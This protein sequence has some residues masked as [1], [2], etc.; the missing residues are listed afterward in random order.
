M[1]RWIHAVRILVVV[2]LLG[3]GHTLAQG[4]VEAVWGIEQGFVTLDPADRGSAPDAHFEELIFDRLI[5]RPDHFNL[6]GTVPEWRPG[7]ATSW[8]ANADGTVWTFNLRQG[9]EFHKGYGPFTGDDVKFSFDRMADP[10]NNFPRQGE[11]NMVREI[12]IVDDYTVEMRLVEPFAPFLLYIAI[13]EG[14]KIVSRRAV[15]EMGNAQFAQNPIGTGPY[16][17]ESAVPGG[18]IVVV[19]NEAYWGGRPEV[20]VAR[21]VVIPDQSVQ[22]LA[23]LRGEVDWIRIRDSTIYRQLLGQPGIQIIRHPTA[24]FQNWEVWLNTE[25]G[26]L[27]D[28]RVRHAMLHALDREAMVEAFIPD[29][30][31]GTAWTFVRPSHVG[32][33]PREELPAYEFDPEKARQLLAEAGY[34]NGFT[35]STVAINQAFMTDMLT[36]MKEYW[37]DVGI[38]LEI[39][40]LDIAAWNARLAAGDFDMWVGSS[41][42]AEIDQVLFNYHSANPPSSRGNYSR[43]NNPW[44]DNLIELQRATLDVEARA[45]IIRELQQIIM[46]D[47]PVL[48]IV[49]IQD[50]TAVSDRFDV[51]DNMFTWYWKTDRFAVR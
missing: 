26:P 21:L 23:M 47:L 6:D 39:E 33:L 45:N 14:G 43:Y 42:R 7:L 46:E 51:P 9:V 5:Q 40:V 30:S 48:P 24:A 4:L 13:Q 50:V 11:Y 31:A 2:T 37:A 16:V 41:G 8:S 35:V 34:A 32:Q 3:L 38:T 25:R 22:A 12:V 17:F 28:K 10:A 18:E 15:E 36:A 49:Y 27:G 19:A 1:K 44:V 29:L 20:D